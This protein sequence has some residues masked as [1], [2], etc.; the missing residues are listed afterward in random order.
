MREELS[1]SQRADL[2]EVAQEL[3]ATSQR[4]Y[5]LPGCHDASLALGEAACLLEEWCVG[6][7]ELLV[8]PSANCP[9]SDAPLKEAVDDIRSIAKW[10]DDGDDKRPLEKSDE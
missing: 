1:W 4:L 10:K 3:R 7:E 2:D 8:Y 6:D 5:N 9:R